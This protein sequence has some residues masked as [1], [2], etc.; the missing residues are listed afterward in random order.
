MLLPCKEAKPNAFLP[1]P[2]AALPIFSE[3]PYPTAI[4]MVSGCVPG[5]INTGSSI[6]LPPTVTFT[7]GFGG[8]TS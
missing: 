2:F 5:I 6:V 1:T 4:P 7:T 3:R 8:F